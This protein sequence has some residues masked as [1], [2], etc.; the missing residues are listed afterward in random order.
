MWR[1]VDQR[2]ARLS[3]RDRQSVRN[4]LASSVLEAHRPTA[5][6]IDLLVEFASGEITF[7]QYRARV[8]ASVQSRH[9]SNET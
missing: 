1:Y 5:G 6:S 4:A 7:E 9:K 3:P 8:L 2:N